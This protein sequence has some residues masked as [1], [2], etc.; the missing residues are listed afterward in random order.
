M[1]SPCKRENGGKFDETLK[2]N[3]NIAMA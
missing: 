1:D 2:R 3:L